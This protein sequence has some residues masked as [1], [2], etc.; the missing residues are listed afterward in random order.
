MVA[1]MRTSAFYIPVRRSHA[2]HSSQDPL[3]RHDPH[4]HMSGLGN[5]HHVIRARTRTR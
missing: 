1:S 5:T 4:R 2:P 3:E